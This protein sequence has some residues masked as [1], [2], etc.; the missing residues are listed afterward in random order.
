MNRGGFSWKRL[1]G[2]SAAKSRLSR[3]IGIPLTRSGRQRKLGAATGCATLGVSIVMIV[4]LLALVSHAAIGQVLDARQL[5][6]T[7]KNAIVFI[8]NRDRTGKESFGTGFIVYPSGLIV[9]C[10]HV[11]GGSVNSIHAGTVKARTW[12]RF[13]N[14][15][16]QSAAL[17]L[18]DTKADLAI[19]K[20][21]TSQ[22]PQLQIEANPVVGGEEVLV[23]GYPLGQALGK[24]VTA[25]RGIVSA[26]RSSGRVLQIDASINPGNS[27][28]PVLNTQGKVV[29]IA[30]AKL[31]GFEGMNFA[32]SSSV[33]PVSHLGVP[34]NIVRRQENAST[35]PTLAEL[36]EG[37]RQFAAANCAEF[38]SVDVGLFKRKNELKEFYP[39]GVD[40]EGRINFRW[41]YDDGTHCITH[42]YYQHFQGQAANIWKRSHLQ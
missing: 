32:V 18:C 28:G 12:V 24:E 11:V 4:I 33:L 23:L 42:S 35:S 27:G 16:T 9:T 34:E 3:Q 8:H 2:I 6:A 25:T 31:T 20:A 41:E 1:L 39:D 5:V 14:G 22:Q 40:A 38:D 7:C 13:T 19:L 15:I 29:G 26:V 30:F 21:D 36:R 37:L 17:V 10:A